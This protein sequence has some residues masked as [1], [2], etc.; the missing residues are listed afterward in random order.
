[1]PTATT[2]DKIDFRV[3][4]GIVFFRWQII[5]LCFLYSLLG[6]V[7]Y[8][9]FTPKEYSSRCL[10][11]VYRDPVLTLAGHDPRWTSFQLHQAML[12]D[13]RF[14]DRVV[15]QLI[16]Q[17]GEVVGVRGNMMLDPSIV[18]AGGVLPTLIVSVKSQN[19]AYGRAFLDRLVVEHEKEWK[20][21]QRHSRDSAAKLLEEELARLDEKIR[22]AEDDVIEYQRL[23]D[24][25]RVSARGEVEQAHLGALVGKRHQ[26][27]TELMMLESQNPEL[28]EESIG[29]ISAVSRL[30]REAGEVG[31]DTPVKD[32]SVSAEVNGAQ[33]ESTSE[34]PAGVEKPDEAVLG[35]PDMRVQLAR[36]KQEETE[37][38]K[39]LTPDHPRLKAL[40]KEIETLESKLELAA[41]IQ[42]ENLR[43]RHKALTI[44]L[45]A[46][47]AAEYRWQAKDMLARQ[48]LAEFQRL[49][50]R[51]NRFEVN[52]SELY[53]RLHQ[54]RVSEELK[55][56]HFSV[57]EKAATNPRPVWPDPMKILLMTVAIGLGSGFGLALLVQVLDNRIQT[58][59]DVEDMLG[60]PF[61]GGVPFWVH[62]GLEKA[63]RPIVTEEHSSGAIE[64]YRALRTNV[65]TALGKANEKV[66]LITSADSREGK[67][68]TALNLA[69]MIAQMGK[70][71]LLAD[72]DLRRGR[73]HRS[74]GVQK[75]P[76]LSDALR[77][78]RSFK[79]VIVGTRIEGLYL[80]PAGSS[81]ENVSEL[82]E[83]SDLV[84]KFV[85]IQDDF[86]Y[87]IV[88]T[89]PVL[90]VTD[91]V[92]TARQGLG[93]VVFVARVNH[94]PKPLVRYALGMLK[95]SRVLGL[96][97]NSI[98]M[99][100]I[101]S[102]YYA[103]QYP[104]YAYYSNAYAYG[105]DHYYTD[106]PGAAG[107]RRRARKRGIG[108]ALKAAIE[109][110]RRSI[111]PAG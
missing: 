7:L 39:N 21:L 111:L 46:I 101:S 50:S 31:P 64:A 85:E 77:E 32:V 104:N 9:Q 66:L 107:G 83:S 38:L 95:D 86:D 45:K 13:P 70:R 81:V 88:D 54:M 73:L 76:G 94:T 82:L 110:A 19:Q 61:L 28:R 44:T 57:V 102:L 20:N 2:Q 97:M 92:I 25:A 18:Q 26:L 87:V 90:R 89:S 43:D 12:R 71:V 98:E 105:Y 1:M 74:L 15:Q 11:S 27:A 4:I 48:R 56:E 40:R 35:W 34:G 41:R 79:E 30:T 91:T 10:I 17:W 108:D 3:Y 103:Y 16:G 6:G 60:V 80:A 84:A 68:L 8:I 96:I 49:E 99:H 72:M 100:R 47:E 65:L 69:I 52:Y 23:N 29:V 75:D 37:L 106:R 67:T 55:A 62:S 59:S 22:Q 109:K 53:S 42:L 93:T 51:V 63:I 36:L 5:A 24:M 14:L 33:K 78:G 58:I